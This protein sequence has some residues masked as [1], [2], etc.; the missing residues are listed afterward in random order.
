MERNPEKPKPD[1]AVY[2]KAT[3]ITRNGRAA[4]CLVSS[5]PEANDKERREA[6]A[7]FY[8]GDPSN[9]VLATDEPRRSRA[10]HEAG[11]KVFGFSNWNA[12]WQP[13][14]PAEKAPLN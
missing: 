10:G 4:H 3:E 14:G 1:I 5:D 7:E 13:R 2:H 6:V 9:V 8:G 11:K 12:N